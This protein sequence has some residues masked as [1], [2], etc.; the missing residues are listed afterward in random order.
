[1]NSLCFSA[2]FTSIIRS[3]QICLSALLHY[4]KF[5]NV[6]KHKVTRLLTLVPQHSV[7]TLHFSLPG[8]SKHFTSAV[9]E[10]SNCSQSAVG[11]CCF[12]H[13]ICTGSLQC[14]LVVPR[15]RTLLH[16][17]KQLLVWILPVWNAKLFVRSD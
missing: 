6:D 14:I 10:K 2:P 9:N 5:V 16:S 3:E 4:I 8:K 12:T 17:S 1:M 15:L 7:V 11:F 13:H